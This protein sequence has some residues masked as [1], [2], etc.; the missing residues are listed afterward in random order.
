MKSQI[1]ES[2]QTRMFF[3]IAFKGKGSS[4]WI[5]TIYIPFHLPQD[6]RK[7]QKI[8]NT[9]K[10]RAIHSDSRKQEQVFPVDPQKGK[11]GAF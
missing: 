11:T 10:Q 6:P 4:C 5:Q 3:F 8:H 1:V 2:S 7:C 9:N